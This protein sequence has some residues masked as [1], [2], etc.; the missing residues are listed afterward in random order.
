M[1]M[2]GQPAAPAS[3]A[4]AP[5]AAAGPANT[6]VPDA[7]HRMDLVIQKNNLGRDQTQT[8]AMWDLQIANRSRELTYRNIEYATTYYDGA[9]NVIYEGSGALDGEIGP[10]ETETFTRINDGLYPLRTA[11]YVIELRSAD[12]FKP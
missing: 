8:M 7:D 10:G 9:G 2:R 11:R 5:R 4:A 3:S 6:P 1:F 12:A